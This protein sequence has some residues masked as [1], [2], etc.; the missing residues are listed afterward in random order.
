MRASRKIASSFSVNLNGSR[1]RP[2]KEQEGENKLSDASS[3]MGES[4]VILIFVFS[5]R[6]RMESKGVGMDRVGYKAMDPGSEN[7][8]FKLTCQ[9]NAVPRASAGSGL[10]SGGP[11]KKAHARGMPPENS[12]VAT[13]N[14]HNKNPNPQGNQE[15][16]SRGDSPGDRHDGVHR[17]GRNQGNHDGDRGLVAFQ[18]QENCELSPV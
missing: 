18:R 15:C 9:G 4:C 13:D 1:A 6:A 3:R 8:G 16:C 7:Q 12:G 10:M 2:G 5:N 11:L 17:D 14:A